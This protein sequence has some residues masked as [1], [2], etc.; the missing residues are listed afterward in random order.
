MH[1]IW[2]AS[3]MKM[4][5]FFLTKKKWVGGV[6]KMNSLVSVKICLHYKCLVIKL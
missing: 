6:V 5:F 4:N 2:Q 3:V 1:T